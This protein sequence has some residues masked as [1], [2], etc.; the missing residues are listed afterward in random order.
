MAKKRNIIN[1]GTKGQRFPGLRIR[2]P[3]GASKK[4]VEAAKKLG[5]EELAGKGKVIRRPR[6]PLVAKLEWQIAET[7]GK[8]TFEVGPAAHRQIKYFITGNGR[9]LT[10]TKGTDRGRKTEVTNL[11]EF[12]SVIKE[13]SRKMGL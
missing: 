6:K 10:I 8:R 5:E 4:A 13:A 2:L 9:H 3:L 12:A 7:I 1:P 11:E